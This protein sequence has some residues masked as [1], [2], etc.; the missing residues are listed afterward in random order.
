MPKTRLMLLAAAGAVAASLAAAPI[1]GA[2]T[3]YLQLDGLPGESTITTTSPAFPVATDSGLIALDSYQWGVEQKLNVGSA[4]TGAGAGKADFTALTVTKD[5]DSTSPTLFQYLASGKPFG[6]AEL[7]VARTT[8]T[9]PKLQIFQRYCLEQVWVGSITDPRP[10]RRPHAG[11]DGVVPVRCRAE[12][13]HQVQCRRHALQQH[14]LRRLEPDHQRP[15]DDVRRHRLRLLRH[16]AA[17][18]LADRLDSRRV[19]GRA[20]LAPDRP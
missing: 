3:Y 9:S 18:P 13:V 8:P 7:A 14:R 17:H 20:Q 6:G 15:G 16:H 1:A 4:T 2:A 11:R 12:P 19:R 10:P 5:V